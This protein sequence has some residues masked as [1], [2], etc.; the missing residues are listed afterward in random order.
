MVTNYLGDRMKTK[1][2]DQ[3]AQKKIHRRTR[4]GKTSGSMSSRANKALL[5]TNKGQPFPAVP[6]PFPVSYDVSTGQA[7]GAVLLPCTCWSPSD[8]ARAELTA[9]CWCRAGVKAALCLS[10]LLWN[11]ML[12]SHQLPSDKQELSNLL[13]GVFFF[14]LFQMCLNLASRS[15]VTLGRAGRERWR[16]SK[17]PVVHEGKYE[18]E[19]QTG[20]GNEGDIWEQLDI[21]RSVRNL[22]T[23]HHTKCNEETLAVLLVQILW[24]PQFVFL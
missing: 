7:T 11:A 3:P 9:G 23:F 1:A 19:R 13:S 2:R 15:K 20:M 10:S 17:P 24:L 12:P 21:I 5:S 4:I 8:N 22:S 14:S 16:D 18:A 6:Y